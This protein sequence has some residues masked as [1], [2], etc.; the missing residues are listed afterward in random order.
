M[1]SDGP[2]AF[3]G[4]GGTIG[5]DVQLFVIFMLYIFKQA[6]H[7]RLMCELMRLMLSIRAPLI[8]HQTSRALWLGEEFGCRY[9]GCFAR[10]L[11]CDVLGRTP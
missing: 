3:S 11:V 5:H 2:I 9:C 1:T 6:Q 4:E 8:V 10:Y 7:L